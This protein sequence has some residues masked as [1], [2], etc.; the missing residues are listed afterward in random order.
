[1]GSLPGRRGSAHAETLL[2][3]C[4]SA[5]QSL[6][7]LRRVTLCQRVRVLAMAQ[8]PKRTRRQDYAQA[9]RQAI[10]GAAR[11]LFAE[12]GYFA[13]KVDDI[14]AEARVA[15]ATVYAVTGGK[16]NLLTTLITAWTT[17]PIVAQTLS[18]IDTSTDPAAIIRE[19][20]SASRT[21]RE[22]YVDVIRVMLATA[23]HDE[24]VARQERTATAIYRAALAPIA[25]RLVQL[26]DLRPGINVADA[27]DLLWFYFGYSSYFT[28]H[29]DNGWSYEQAEHWLAGQAITALLSPP[30]QPR[31]E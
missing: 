5:S 3:E 22:A 24:A 23:P 17:D 13:T 14:A 6:T 9:T 30:R 25:E 16:Q 10:I 15:P 2:T 18:R 12:R 29:D 19:V 28:L 27:V 8:T 1:M 7:L 31:Y 11:Q 21:M 26:G 4:C 20:A